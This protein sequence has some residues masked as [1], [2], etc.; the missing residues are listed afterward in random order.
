M[1]YNVYT[2]Y[3]VEFRCTFQHIWR[4]WKGEWER[5][6]TNM[7]QDFSAYQPYFFSCQEQAE[8]GFVDVV[9]MLHFYFRFYHDQNQLQVQAWEHK[10]N[11][12]QVESKCL[13]LRISLPPETIQVLLLCW[14]YGK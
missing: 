10:I 3:H 14:R 11:R 1:L 6:I 12:L 2:R 9:M 8:G 7:F 13:E 4:N 5:I